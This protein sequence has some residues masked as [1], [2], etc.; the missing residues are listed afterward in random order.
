MEPILVQ[1]ATHSAWARPVAAPGADLAAILRQGRVIAGDVLQTLTG[2]TVLIGI[3]RH[4]VPARSQTEL[5]AGRRYFFEVLSGGE[6]VEVRALGTTQSGD[7]ALLRALRGVLGAEQPLGPMFEQ[8]IKELAKSRTQSGDP[9]GTLARLE[10]TLGAQ[11]FDP[12]ADAEQL[13]GKLRGSGSTYE[14]RWA[15]IALASTSP[16][17]WTRVARELANALISEWTG[18]SGADLDDFRAALR[19]ALVDLFLGTGTDLESA[20]VRWSHA[21]PELDLPRDLAALLERV[22]SQVPDSAAKSALL[23]RSTSLGLEHLP[24]E[25]RVAIL[26][27]LVGVG[28]TPA[29]MS[30]TELAAALDTMSRD[31]KAELMRACVALDAGPARTAIERALANIEA[32]Q[33]INFARHAAHE[34]S[35]WSL[36]V[37]DGSRWSTAHLFV[38]RDA[39]RTRA[40]DGDDAPQQRLSLAVEF[41]HTG[42]VHVDFLMRDD[43]VSLRLSTSSPAV[44]EFMRARLPDLEQ[45]LGFDGRVVR[46]A[47][48]VVPEAVLREDDGVHGSRFLTDHHVMDMTG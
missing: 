35:H 4:R 3:G 48:S 31:V 33:L 36:P 25:M 45:R 19:A 2:G 9:D 1:N 40:R 47:M 41:T 17:E 34:P 6:P 26:R 13:A 27:G 11:L 44:A 28:V 43:A 20:L 32:E 15:R 42:P 16:Q 29:T 10:E 12:G 21:D 23:A 39:D 22:L 5:E 37:L 46:T 18:A 7:S 8:L 24:R 14:A 30:P 38:H